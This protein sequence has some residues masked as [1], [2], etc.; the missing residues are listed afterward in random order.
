MDNTILK[1]KNVVKGKKKVKFSLFIN[2]SPGI[3]NP[4]PPNLDRIKIIPPI[5]IIKK[6]IVIKSF[7]SPSRCKD[8]TLS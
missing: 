8:F 5:S 6:P 1:I 2:I 4:A 7:A 3:L